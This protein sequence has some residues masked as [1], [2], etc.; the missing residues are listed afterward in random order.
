MLLDVL[1]KLRLLSPSFVSRSD[2]EPRGRGYKLSPRPWWP[3][4]SGQAQLHAS[5]H[6]LHQLHGTAA[7]DAPNDTLSQSRW[8]WSTSPC[9][10]LMPSRFPAPSR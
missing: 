1:L 9:K 3:S 8:P 10:M 7:A 6:T 5:S 2:S 4:E